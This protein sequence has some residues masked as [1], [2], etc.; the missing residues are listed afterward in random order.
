MQEKNENLILIEAK[1]CSL[2]LL[3]LGTI[4]G[5]GR[6]IQG[7]TLTKAGAKLT[8]RLRNQTFIS[9]LKQDIPWFDE[10]QHGVG[11]LAGILSADCVAIDNSYGNSFG[12]LFEALGSVITTIVIAFYYS[13]GEAI[14]AIW[15]IPII[16]FLSLFEV[17]YSSKYAN[18]KKSAIA[19]KIAV[20]AIS[21]IR[22]VVSLGQ[23]QHMIERYNRAIDESYYDASVK[24]CILRG[25]IFGL[26]QLLP[27]LFFIL[28]MCYGGTLVVNSG[29]PSENIFR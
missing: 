2:Y 24:E 3:A 9:L 29:L 22:T 14:V 6:I 25:P 19:V 5:F 17:Y 28:S 20:E 15:I 8:Q 27:W 13:W 1:N 7:Y 23:E 4:I 11:Q 26:T 21:N 16:V 12:R 18:T 10:P